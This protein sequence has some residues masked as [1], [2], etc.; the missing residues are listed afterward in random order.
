MNKRLSL[1]DRLYHHAVDYIFYIEQ[2]LKKNYF[3]E[4]RIFFDIWLIEQWIDKNSGAW[5]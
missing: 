1:H 4:G 2:E 5:A 3:R